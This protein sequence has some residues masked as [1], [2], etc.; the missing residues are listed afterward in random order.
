MVILDVDVVV[1]EVGRKV[2]AEPDAHDEVDERDPIED[3]A[4]EGHEPEGSEQGA[5]DAQHGA[6]GGQAVREEEEGDNDHH[7]PRH[8]D[9]L[10]RLVEDG[11]VLVRVE[12]VA[13]VHSRLDLY[14]THG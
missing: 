1:A 4:P 8:Q 10:D 2:H 12:E 9:A 13:V 3:D 11:E 14:Q 7:Q 6:G 5:H